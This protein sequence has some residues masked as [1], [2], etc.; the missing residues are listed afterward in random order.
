MNVYIW[1]ENSL[2]FTANTAN[3]T[4]QLTNPNGAAEQSLETSTN[5]ISW[6]SYTIWDT[7]TLT[8]I[9]DKIYWRNTSTTNTGFCQN[10]K[11]YQFVMTGSISASGDVTSLINKNWTDTLSYYCFY[12]LF[13]EC[14]S[15]TTAPSLPV[16][17]VWIGCCADMFQWCTALTTCPELKATTLAQECYTSMF[18][19]CTSLTTCPS[20]PATTLDYYCY[21]SMF[22]WCTSLTALPKLPA[23]TLPSYCYQGMFFWCSNIKLSTSNSWIYT[24]A[25]RIP[26]TWTGSVWSDSMYS[27]FTSTGWTFTWTPSINT[28]YY[29]SNTVV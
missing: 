28:T 29:T 20:L 12:H 15:L 5:W 21:N 10:G 11:P 2:C 13:Y 6:S 16:T 17:T 3:S 19:W 25:Y 9:W 22:K 8:N 7:I 23:T 4:V 14:T 1:K 18:Y 24:T 27:M 26:T